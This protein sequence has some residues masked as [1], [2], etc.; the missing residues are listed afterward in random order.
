MTAAGAS[1]IQDLRF[2]SGAGGVAVW[3]LSPQY[4]LKASYSNYLAEY[5]KYGN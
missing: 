5:E 2:Q 1:H 4:I 3:D